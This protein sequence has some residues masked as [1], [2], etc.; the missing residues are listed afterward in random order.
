MRL[1]A[2]SGMI[3]RLFSA[4]PASAGKGAGRLRRGLATS[5]TAAIG[6]VVITIAA[7]GVAALAAFYPRP[8]RPA[9][10]AAP[11]ARRPA[12]V[13]RRPG[14][15]RAGRRRARL[16]ALAALFLLAWAAAL[17]LAARQA[18]TSPPAREAVLGVAAAEPERPA[19]AGGAGSAGGAA[20]AEGSAAATLREARQ[21]RVVYFAP[22]SAVLP[23]PARRLLDGLLPLLRDHPEFAVFIEGHC[24]L[25]GTPQ[26]RA[27]L[28]LMR[29]RV[30]EHYLY[31]GGWAPLI[32]PRVEGAGGARPVTRDPGRQALNRRVE[33][34]ITPE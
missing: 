31:G 33:V 8:T 13:P 23:A 29:A 2:R 12:V 4:P 26:G 27:A 3:R 9:G 6:T 10:A 28:S 16:V 1:P 14:G 34:R 22:E 17:V 19:A 21:A 30:V 25:F 24:A 7:I 5:I 32:E 18:A 20:A 15:R 11:R